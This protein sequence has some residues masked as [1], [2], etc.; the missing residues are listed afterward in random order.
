MFN[1]D[2]NKENWKSLVDEECFVSEDLTSVDEN[3][4]F[5]PQSKLQLEELFGR[6]GSS[7]FGGCGV[8]D[9]YCIED[10]FNVLSQE[11]KVLVLKINIEDN[12]PN[13]EWNYVVDYPVEVNTKFESPFLKLISEVKQAQPS[14]H[15]LKIIDML[16]EE[17]IVFDEI[18]YNIAQ[19][20]EL[21]QL[22][23]SFCKEIVG[24]QVH[25]DGRIAYDCRDHQQ[26]FFIESIRFY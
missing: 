14:G 3:N 4:L 5:G 25:V 2:Y 24:R 22:L 9:E 20:E 23:H 6:S 16:V 8:V 12:Y 13:F 15:L 21:D 17:E 1:E 7:V 18:Q 10:T 11:V 19:G 26:T